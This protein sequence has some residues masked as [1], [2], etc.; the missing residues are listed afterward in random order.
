VD[1]IRVSVDPANPKLL[2]MK[3]GR[4]INPAR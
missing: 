3:T 1:W 2:S 4:E